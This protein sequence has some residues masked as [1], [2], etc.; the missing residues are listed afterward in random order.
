MRAGTYRVE[1][2]T[3]AGTNVALRPLISEAPAVSRHP[4]EVTGG[5][6]IIGVDAGNVAILDLAPLVRCEAQQVEELFQEQSLRLLDAAGTVSGL[7]GD[8]N[9]AQIVEL[10]DEYSLARCQSLMT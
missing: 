6:N 5:S 7:A 1:V 10:G 9:D 4:A 2:S 8:V 3:I